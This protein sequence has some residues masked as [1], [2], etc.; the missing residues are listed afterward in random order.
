[1]K[2]AIPIWNDSVSNVLDFANTLILID[3]EDGIETGR[4]SVSLRNDS[5]IERAGK[6]KELGIDMLIC[7]AISRA[8]ANL[9]TGSGIQVLPYVT[10]RFDDVLQTY[11]NGELVKSQFTMPGY[12]R[13]ARRGFGKWHRGCRWRGGQQ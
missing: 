2:I 8:L 13:G 5:P 3:I 12:W 6:I 1:M 7:G 9:L 10:G 4:T 11:L